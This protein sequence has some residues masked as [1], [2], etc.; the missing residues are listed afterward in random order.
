MVTGIIARKV[1]MTQIFDEKGEVQKWTMVTLPRRE[2]S[3]I[4]LSP[5]VFSHGPPTNSGA[6]RFRGVGC[7]RVSLFGVFVRG[8]RRP[9]K[10]RI[11]TSRCRREAR[12]MVV[13]LLIVFR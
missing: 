8:I 9:A 2:A 13:E 4:G 10:V 3:E 6:A 7:S 11:R 1:G 12:W 5:G